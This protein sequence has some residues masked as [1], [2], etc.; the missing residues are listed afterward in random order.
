[1]S[2]TPSTA[3]PA[4]APEAPAVITRKAVVSAPMTPMPDTRVEVTAPADTSP[5]EWERL[6]I[7][8]A[9][10]TGSALPLKVAF[11]E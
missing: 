3:E 8:A 1:M 6:A 7:K 5:A 4:I 11:Q 2:D 9:G 10:L